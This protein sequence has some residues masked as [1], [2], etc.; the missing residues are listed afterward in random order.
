[1]KLNKNAIII[2]IL[3]S[4]NGI[5]SQTIFNNNSSGKINPFS[6]IVE[7]TLDCFKG[8]NLIFHSAAIAST[9][10][11]SQSGIDYKVHEY[12]ADNKQFDAFS[13]PAAILGYILPTALSSGMYLYGKA[14]GDNELTA[15]GSAAAQ[16]TIVSV[17]YST[18]LKAVTGRPGPNTK[19]DDMIEESKKFRFGLLRGGIHYGWPS[20]HLTT[21]TALITSLMSFYK[22]NWLINIGGGLLLGYM[23]FS[24]TAHEGASMHWFSDVVAGTLIGLVIGINIG[25]NFHKLYYHAGKEK[26]DDNFKI[27]PVITP[28]Y[29]ALY[30]KYSF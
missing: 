14:T 6:G 21:N 11:L 22:N 10:F 23:F 24:V 29:Q 30:F 8:E 7:N 12:F 16:A 1:M 4:S 19:A 2:I 5:F 15:A 9:Y 18:I 3:F 26:S 17:V 25:N 13:S 20:G 28:S 27:S